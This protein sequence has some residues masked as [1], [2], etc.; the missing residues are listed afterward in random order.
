MKK[1]PEIENFNNPVEA[2]FMYRVQ[3]SYIRSVEL[4]DSKNMENI[5]KY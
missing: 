3:L 2:P 1:D 4:Y 5:Y